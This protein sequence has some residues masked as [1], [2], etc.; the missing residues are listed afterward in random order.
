MT[1]GLLQPY[2][3]R[4]DVCTDNDVRAR[5][6]DCTNDDQRKLSVEMPWPATAVSAAAPALAFGWFADFKRTDQ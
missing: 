3:L 5:D 2:G 6:D 1:G 4:N